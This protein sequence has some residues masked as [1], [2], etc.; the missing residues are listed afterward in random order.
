VV[1]GA[2]R[3]PV[4]RRAPFRELGA[5]R[6]VEGVAGDPPGE[7]R[8][9]ARRVGGGETVDADQWTLVPRL[10]GVGA[11][12]DGLR[13]GKVAEPVHGAVATVGVDVADGRLP[14]LLG[15]REEREEP[16]GLVDVVG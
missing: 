16:H 5:L 1:L 9:D 10:S 4:G 14:E 12:A 3:R 6:G 7:R 2:L 11:P 15:L 13:D 8:R